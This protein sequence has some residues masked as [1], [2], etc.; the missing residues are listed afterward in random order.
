MPFPDPS[1]QPLHLINDQM[2]QTLRSFLSC[3]VWEINWSANKRPHQMVN[4]RDD[5]GI[6]HTAPESEVLFEICWSKASPGWESWRARLPLWLPCQQH[7]QQRWEATQSLPRTHPGLHRRCRDQ[8]PTALKAHREQDISNH[9]EK[10]QAWLF[11]IIET[12]WVS[13]SKKKSRRETCSG[14]KENQSPRTCQ[15]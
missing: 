4:R 15:T 3:L 12:C 2:L 14:R 6:T 7:T 13:T 11:L 10:Y 1:P 9:T 5:L 8:P